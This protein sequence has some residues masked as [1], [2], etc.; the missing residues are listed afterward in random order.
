MK[1]YKLFFNLSLLFSDVLITPVFFT[2]CSSRG[3]N[4]I[5]E[6]TSK[7]F[8]S[9]TEIDGEGNIK[10]N[11]L[12]GLFFTDKIKDVSKIEIR[13][14]ELNDT[15]YLGD[16]TPSFIKFDNNIYYIDLKISNNDCYANEYPIE[17]SFYENGQLVQKPSIYTL[18]IEPQIFQLNKHITISPKFDTR[19]QKIK[20]IFQNSV[21]KVVHPTKAL[22]IKDFSINVTFKSPD[23]KSI[24]ITNMSIKNINELELTIDLTSDNL[25]EI[26]NYYINLEISYDITKT[27]SIYY[28]EIS[29]SYAGW[30]ELVLADEKNITI[31]K[32]TE[33]HFFAVGYITNFVMSGFINKIDDIELIDLSSNEPIKNIDVSFIKQLNPEKNLPLYDLKITVTMDTKTLSAQ[34]FKIVSTALPQINFSSGYFLTIK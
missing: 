17:I 6:P 24:E 8:Y 31:E 29:A 27:K 28:Y 12:I 7:L 22:S 4:P 11:C 32:P 15:N 14:K 33:T 30:D 25:I 21:L 9:N 26:K 18:K 20:Y 16:L 2:S 34:P 10:T 5:V 13:A 3:T 1:K 23:I 19:E